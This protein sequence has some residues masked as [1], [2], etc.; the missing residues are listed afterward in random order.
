[1]I[2]KSFDAELLFVVN[3]ISWL[4]WYF[5]CPRLVLDCPRTGFGDFSDVF[6]D[7]VLFFLSFE[8]VL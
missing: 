4:N 5:D 8:F 2:I 6:S 1:M 7:T 3:Q